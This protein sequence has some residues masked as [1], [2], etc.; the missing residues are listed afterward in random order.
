MNKKSIFIFRA[1]RNKLTRLGM[2]LFYFYI[3][4][5]LIGAAGILFG[6]TMLL[7]K[8]VLTHDLVTSSW[9]EIIALILV[10]W[11]MIKVFL[12]E[13][14]NLIDMGNKKELQQQPDS[15]EEEIP[16]QSNVIPFN[17]NSGW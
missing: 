7:Q 4:F 14:L 9:W 11:L 6:S 3:I 15:E 17:K 5:S 13:A 8:L 1:A 12:R 10:S 16:E 2:A